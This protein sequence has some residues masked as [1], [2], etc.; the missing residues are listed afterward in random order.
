MLPDQQK[1][2]LRAIV[3]KQ[4]KELIKNQTITRIGKDSLKPMILNCRL[5][6]MEDERRDV[7]IKLIYIQRE[8]SCFCFTAADPKEN[9]LIQ[10]K[11]GQAEMID[12]RKRVRAYKKFAMHVHEAFDSE[13]TELKKKVCAF[14]KSITASVTE[15]D[16]DKKS[17]G[18]SKGKKIESRQA[19]L[20]VLSVFNRS[21]FKECIEFDLSKL[22]DLI[23]E[24][25]RMRQAYIFNGHRTPQELLEEEFVLEMSNT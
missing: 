2:S 7:L 12:I 15:Q 17:K 24:M 4:G 5:E 6:I 21:M 1:M 16:K 20:E 19:A 22:L 3:S 13:N 14:A 18:R 8:K 10:F 25:L 9:L 11:L 23:D